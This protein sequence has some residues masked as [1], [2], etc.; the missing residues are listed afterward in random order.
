MNENEI[1]AIYVLQFVLFFTANPDI[2]VKKITIDHEF[3]FLACDGMYSSLVGGLHYDL[4]Y[5]T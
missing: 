4:H 1:I 3:L 5:E 2:T